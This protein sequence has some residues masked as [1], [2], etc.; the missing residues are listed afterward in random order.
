VSSWWDLH[1]LLTDHLK[2]RGFS[3]AS[4]IALRLLSEGIDG[5][6]STVLLAFYLAIDDARQEWRRRP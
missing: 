4:L 5:A 6:L 1:A 2:R 3:S